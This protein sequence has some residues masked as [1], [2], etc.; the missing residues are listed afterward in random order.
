VPRLRLRL[1]LMAVGMLAIAVVS[2]TTVIIVAFS[3]WNAV[4]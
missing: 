1:G 4:T 2:L 3:S